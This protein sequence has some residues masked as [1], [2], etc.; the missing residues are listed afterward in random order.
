MEI[1][2]GSLERI[3]SYTKNFEHERKH[4][5]P[6]DDNMKELAPEGKI[7]FKDV[8]L[9]YRPT[10]DLVLKNLNFT[11]ESGEK[12]G[13]VGRTGAG[14]SSLVQALFRMIEIENFED[15]SC[16]IYIDGNRI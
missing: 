11:I 15:K 2:V 10:A 8:S 4:V 1:A 16:G 6:A 7:E 14:K 5:L 12:V 3:D 9:R 13:C